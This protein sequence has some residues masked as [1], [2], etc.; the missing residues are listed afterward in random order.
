MEFHIRQLHTKAEA[1]D[2]LTRFAEGVRFPYACLLPRIDVLLRRFAFDALDFVVVFSPFRVHLRTDEFTGEAHNAHVQPVVGIEYHHVT[3]VHVH[4]RRF[5]KKS[6][7]IGL[8]PHLHH[9]KRPLTHGQGHAFQ[10]IKH[11]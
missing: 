2:D 5:A 8:E 6:F 9:I 10:P 1:F 7:S 4:G 11:R 3:D